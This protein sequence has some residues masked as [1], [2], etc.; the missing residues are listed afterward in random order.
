[1]LVFSRGGGSGAFTARDQFLLRK[2]ERVWRDGGDELAL[3]EADLAALAVSDRRPLPDSFAVMA[4][5]AARSA[6][7]LAA[8]RFHVFVEHAAGPSGAT[9]LGRFCHADP[10]LH[11]RVAEMLRV[12]ARARPDVAYAEIVHLPEGR[13]GN[14]VSRPVLRDYEIV[15]LGASGAPRDRQ[16]EL[17]DLIV[18]VDGNRVVL[19]SRRLGKD[20][21]PRL[22]NAHNYAVRSLGAYRFLCALQRQGVASVATWSW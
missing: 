19:R 12:E 8:G 17:A 16:I 3:D 11:A 21:L 13:I 9:L 7:D 20:V 2:L 5:L 18:R 15:F 1:G 10:D 6:E 4:Q 22:S 14:I